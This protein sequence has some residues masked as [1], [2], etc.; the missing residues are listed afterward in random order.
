MIVLWVPK[1][2]PCRL[3]RWSGPSPPC[4]SGSHRCAAFAVADPI[5]YLFIGSFMLAEAMFTTV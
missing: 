5:I 1:R 3:R 4:C 2:C